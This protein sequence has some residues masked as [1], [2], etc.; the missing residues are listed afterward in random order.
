VV[1]SVIHSENFSPSASERYFAICYNQLALF[2]KSSDLAILV[3]KIH[4]W[5]Q[6]EH[7]GYLLRDGT[8]WIYNGYK[9]WQEQIPWLSTDQ[10]GRYMRALERIGWAITDR[11]WRLNRNIGFTTKAPHFQ[12]DNQR[13]WYRLDYQRIFED[14][15]FDLLFEVKS[16]EPQAKRQKRPRGANLQDC[17]MQSTDLQIATG[18]SADSS[19]Y[20]ENQKLPHSSSREREEKSD[21]NSQILKASQ[22]NDGSHPQ[23]EVDED[24]H[25]AAD[26]AEAPAHAMDSLRDNY[27]A[28]GAQFS[29]ASKPKP[30]QIAEAQVKEIWETSP[31]HPYPVFLNWRVK[32]HYEPQGGKWASGGRKYAYSEFYNNRLATTTMLFPEFIAYMQSVAQDC[33]QRQA[34]GGKVILPSLFEISPNLDEESVRQL[35]DNFQHLIDTGAQIAVPQG[36]ASI[37][38]QPQP[39]S[40]DQATESRFAQ[41]LRLKKSQPQPPR[42]PRPRPEERSLSQVVKDQRSM[43]AFFPLIREEIERWAE[44]TPGVRIGED[45]PELELG[46]RADDS[47]S[48]ESEASEK[49]NVTET[50]AQIVV[51]QEIAIPSCQ[52]PQPQ[53]DDQATE[54]R[55]AQL[56]RL[57]RSQPQPPQPQTVEERSLRRVVDDKR[58]MWDF[59][60]LMREEIKRWAEV[61]PGVKIGEDGPE[62]EPDTRVIDS[63]LVESEG[64]EKAS[65]TET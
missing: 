15:G 33:H 9:E 62:L 13:K 61:T 43:W 1:A 63:Q 30:S 59:F 10:I 3:Q 16:S 19:I 29:T 23:A 17:T 64:S 56:L 14:T 28:D 8:K 53:S 35:V 42:P 27:S 48:V 25:S 58:F 39:R 46:A 21:P 5:L 47:Q 20:K 45:G 50:G 55:F 2:L 65:A 32:F 7:S 52:Q 57:R 6:N 44:V 54:S 12:E 22:E 11:Y 51:P 40:D 60:P 49:A 36:I 26:S 18:D 38:Q 31:G 34:V 37:C 4:Y 41:L 24:S